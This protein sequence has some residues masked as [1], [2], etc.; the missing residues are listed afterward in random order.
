MVYY[1]YGDDETDDVTDVIDA[2]V[3]VSAHRPSTHACRAGHAQ[4]WLIV[5]S[6]PVASR[7]VRHPLPHPNRPL[8]PVP[9]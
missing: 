3:D 8:H 5:R 6:E 1:A 7:P 2:I 9:A 4:S